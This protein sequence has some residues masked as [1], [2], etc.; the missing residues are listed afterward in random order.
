M[1]NRGIKI[2]TAVL[3]VIMLLSMSTAVLAAGTEGTEKTAGEKAQKLRE[4]GQKIETLFTHYA[5]DLLDDYL[6][7]KQEH[8]A[9]HQY[10]KAQHQ[11][12]KEQT[13]GSLN[14][15]IDAFVAGEMSGEEAKA[16]IIEIRDNLKGYRDELSV[17]RDAKLAE[18]EGLKVQRESLRLQIQ[19]ALKADEVDEALMY[20]LMEQTLAQFRA[21]LEM[22]YKYA[23]QVD[24]VKAEYFPE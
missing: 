7:V 16:T 11:S 19:T 23:A 17:I 1:K 4:A 5:P 24:A 9:F 18:K 15:I 3:V 2:L 14:S 12:F 6:S 13:R 8:A 10:R 20:S 21:H 22:D